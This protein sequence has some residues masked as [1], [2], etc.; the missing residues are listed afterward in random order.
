V[1][2]TAQAERTQ[3]ISTEL[4]PQKRNPAV[5]PDVIPPVRN[6]IV[7]F[8][9]QLNADSAAFDGFDRVND[10]V[11]QMEVREE[12][13]YVLQ[14][15]IR[16]VLFF[17][18]MRHFREEL[19]AKGL[20]VYYAELDEPDN[21]GSFS[22]ELKRWCELLKP[23]RLVA[24]EPGDY[25]V[26]MLLEE[27]ASRLNLPLELRI[28]RSFLCSAEE[29]RKLASRPGKL[30]LESFYHSMRRK[31][32]ILLN[33]G[34]P[35]GG[36]WNFDA[37]NRKRLPEKLLENIPGWKQ[38]PPDA[39]TEKV[40]QL[41]EQHF[42]HAPGE[43]A[44]FDYP[45][46]RD[47]AR[48]AL[49]NFLDERLALFGPYQDAMSE[50]QPYLF[51][52]RL[53]SSLNLHL[54]TPREVINAA[55]QA[56]EQHRAPLASV[57]GFVRQ[58][59]GWREFVHGMYWLHMP[60]YAASN[61][62][63]ADLPVPRFLWTSETEMNCVRSAVRS[64]QQHAYTHH[65]Q[66]LMVLGL[67]CLLL[68]VHPY[69]FHEWHISMFVDAIDWVSLPNALGMSQFGDGGMMGTKPYCASGQYIHRM[70]NYCGSCRYH[71]ER[72]NGP[73][74]CPFTTLYWDFL[75]RHAERFAHN[76]RMHYQLL[77]LQRRDKHE[78]IQ[79]RREADRLKATV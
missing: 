21:T 58:V 22:G 68:G 52:S 2:V 12:A 11:L 39:I 30:I 36:K 61:V 20:C 3:E 33:H 34:A 26:V 5:L 35:V 47:Q 60:K 28:D 10:A 24:V 32:R 57:E 37:Q 6:L 77:N 54:L 29:F 70:S 27:I 50:G 53:S 75:D 23:V 56:Y 40:K 49:G 1:R 17:S 76:P 15:K 67:H 31:F 71:P 38:P 9:D 69:R 42:P 55:V 59:L 74:A 44:G 79:I 65:I 46:T 51:H 14:H 73:D 48:A 66:R 45:V 43:L 13:E 7:V 18:A 41:V 16:L 4:T 25:R 64:L 62:L 8:G 19:R 78:L 63:G 72:A